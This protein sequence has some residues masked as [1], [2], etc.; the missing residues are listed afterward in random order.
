[1]YDQKY[2]NTTGPIIGCLFNTSLVESGSGC[3]PSL[4][5]RDRRPL[6]TCALVNW[7]I[8]VRCKQQTLAQHALNPALTRYLFFAKPIQCE[9]RDG[10]GASAERRFPCNL[11]VFDERCGC[12]QIK[13]RDGDGNLTVLLRDHRLSLFRRAFH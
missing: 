8:S 4:S 1:M 7:A 13:F 11:G 3:E 2:K 6:S 5:I 12:G 9:Q 10:R